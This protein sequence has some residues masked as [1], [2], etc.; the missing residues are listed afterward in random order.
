[1]QTSGRRA[2]QRTVAGYLLVDPSAIA[3]PPR[4]GFIVSRAVGGAVVRNRVRR[5]FR[6]L[7]RHRP[8]PAGSLLVL[9]VLPP[10]AGLTSAALDTELDALL[11]RLGASRT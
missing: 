1:M 11:R 4:V 2:G 7:L 5:Q 10:A 3:S 8:L 6:E 9:R